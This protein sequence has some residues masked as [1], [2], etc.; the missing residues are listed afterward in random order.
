MNQI[1]D[2]F[3]AGII[4]MVIAAIIRIGGPKVFPDSE[5]IFT[6]AS[7]AVFVAGVY[8]VIKNR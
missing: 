3:W 5:G 4:I 1:K 6:I 8:C 2:G 7:I